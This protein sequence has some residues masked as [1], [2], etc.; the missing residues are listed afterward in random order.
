MKLWRALSVVGA[1]NF[2][3]NFWKRENSQKREKI[4]CFTSWNLSLIEFLSERSK[5]LSER[6]CDPKYGKSL[7]YSDR[8]FFKINYNSRMRKP[9]SHPNNADTAKTKDPE[10]KKNG[11]SSKNVFTQIHH[12]FLV[13][14]TNGK[15]KFE[16]SNKRIAD[17]KASA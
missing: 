12:S 7:N 11:L 6:K 17:I 8:L 1:I 16:K 15:W 9:S 13:F 2:E 4:S 3:L 10:L 5:T 14:F